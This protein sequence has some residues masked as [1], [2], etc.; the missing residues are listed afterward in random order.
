M[1]NFQMNA[2]PASYALSIGAIL[3]SLAA[4]GYT[5]WS[6]QASSTPAMPETVIQEVAKAEAPAT[7]T[8]ER[9]DVEA[10]VHDY[11]LA[12]PKIMMDMQAELEKIQQEERAVA[13]KAALSENKEMIFGSDYQVEIGNADAPI[14]IVEFFDYNCGFCQRALG[15]MMKFVD[16]DPQVKFILKEFPVLGE[17]SLDAHKAS[18]AFSHLMPA[19][20]AEF[21]TSLL[22]APGR[23]DGSVAMD[24]AIQLGA[25]KTQMIEEMKKPYILGAIKEVY[26]LA[27]SLGITGTPSYVVGDEVVFG[28]VGHDSLNAKVAAIKECGKATC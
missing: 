22:G 2:K 19:K 18:L 17:A 13:Q 11:L 16:E 23:K 20:A 15:D 5:Y 4:A 10:I 25:D 3:I 6:R 9:D 24:L 21:H 7:Q 27:D 26:G 14:T 1:E 12:N 28:A 8:L